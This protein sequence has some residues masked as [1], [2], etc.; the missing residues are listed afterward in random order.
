MDMA[1]FDQI[2]QAGIDADDMASYGMTGCR[3]CVR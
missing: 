1:L 2:E 3:H